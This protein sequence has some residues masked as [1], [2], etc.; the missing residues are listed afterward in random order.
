MFWT[1]V[2]LLTFEGAPSSDL[3]QMQVMFWEVWGGV[4]DGGFLLPSLS[5]SLPQGSIRQ[6]G[7]LSSFFAP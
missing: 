6:W 2:V 1:V 4:C 3:V 5:P 7:T